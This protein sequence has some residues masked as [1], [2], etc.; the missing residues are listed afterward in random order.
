MCCLFKVIFLYLSNL[1]I[2]ICYFLGKCIKFY[3]LS[4]I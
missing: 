2:Y 4:C 1:N 3:L